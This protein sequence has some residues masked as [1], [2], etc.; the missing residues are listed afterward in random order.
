MTTEELM[1]KI[2]KGVPPSLSRVNLKVSPALARVVERSM[3]KDPNARPASF[4]T[5][6]VDLKKLVSPTL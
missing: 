4:A 5:L 1:P 3:S 6:K 2:L